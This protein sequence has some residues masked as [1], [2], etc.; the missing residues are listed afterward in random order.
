MSD[1][2]SR[3]EARISHIQALLGET[4]QPNEAFGKT[5][6]ETVSQ[7]APSPVRLSAAAGRREAPEWLQPII[8]EA[9]GKTGL[10]SE[11]ITAVIGA[12]SGFQPGLTSP[13]GAQGL[14]QLMPGTARELGVRNPLDARENVLAG[15]EYLR[16]QV[17][18]FGSLEKAI[19]AYNAGPGAVQRHGG[20]PP[21]RETKNYVQ[22]VMG[23]FR[24]LLNRRE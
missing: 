11:L 18:E 23:I 8:Q 1:A 22:R 3:I 14:M 9:A 24:G 12:E 10:Q 13:K 2:I 19:A 20:V 15:S 6:A 17:K 4:N 5:L 16:E 7:G 21:Y